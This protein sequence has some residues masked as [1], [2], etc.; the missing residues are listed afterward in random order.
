MKTSRK[1]DITRLQKN[2]K[3]VSGR[4]SRGQMKITQFLENMVIKARNEYLEGKTSGPFENSED[5]T[6][7]LNRKKSQK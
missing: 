3:M 5:L 4:G 7:H 6:A 2:Q 1:K